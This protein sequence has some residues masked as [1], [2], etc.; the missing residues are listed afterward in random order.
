V[1]IQS[2]TGS[3]Q[4]IAALD[5]SQDAG[6]ELS[7][8]ATKINYT[9]KAQANIAAP[10]QK[11]QGIAKNLLGSLLSQISSITD[12]QGMLSQVQQTFGDALGLSG[13]T[14]Q[15]GSLTSSFSSLTSLAGSF[16]DLKDLAG[17]LGS[18]TDL[19]SALSSITQPLSSLSD[20]LDSVTGAFDSLSGASDMLSDLAGS[21]T[22]SSASQNLT[23]LSNN[24]QTQTPSVATQVT[25]TSVSASKSI[26]RVTSALNAAT[27]LQTL[28][29]K[30]SQPNSTATVAE[31]SSLMEDIYKILTGVPVTEA[32]S[33]LSDQVDTM[34]GNITGVKPDVDAVATLVNSL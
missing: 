18:F 14:S 22:M 17:S 27:T 10:I 1:I 5:I 34:N 20:S 15:L 28:G 8:N 30:M 3:I 19:G 32:L 13:L 31:L 33:N 25:T 26:D 2:I 11:I 16:G 6:L 12:L 23:N 4:H 24:T 7:G 29:I 21:G 9:A